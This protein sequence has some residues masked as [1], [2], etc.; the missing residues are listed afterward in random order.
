M[1]AGYLFKAR[2]FGPVF[3]PNGTSGPDLFNRWTRGACY[4]DIQALWG[5]R[6]LF[7]HRFPYL[8]GGMDS[9]GG[10]VGG[11]LEYPVLS[12]L[13]IW[14]AAVPSATD[15]DLL[16][17]SALMLGLCGLGIAFL[18]ARLTGWRSLWWSLAPALVLYTVLNWDMFAVVATVGAI[19]AVVA[20]TRSGTGRGDAGTGHRTGWL[21]LAAVLLAVGGLLKLYP[22]MFVLPIALWIALGDR[23]TGADPE[24]RRDRWL[25]AAGFGGMATAVFVLVNLPF[26][27]WNFDGW[28]AAYRFQW[29]RPIDQ[30]T[31]SIWYWGLRPYSESANL[32]LQQLMALGATAAT[33]LSLIAICLFGL[34]RR[35]RDG[36]YPWLQVSA[37]MLCA[38]LIFNKVHS[39]QYALWMIPFLV[40]IRIPA[41]W[42]LGYFVADVMTG[43]GFLKMI[44]SGTDSITASVWPQVLIL[45]VWGRVVLLALLIVVFLRAEPAFGVGGAVAALSGP[46]DPVDRHP[47]EIPVVPSR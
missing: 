42:I 8:N 17:W 26:V 43:V 14:L 16:R 20:G 31:N 28:W 22:L 45:G 21:M 34:W 38:Y 6:Q 18:L 13:L 29:K 19:A 27:L 4:T 2:C 36:V 44:G 5:G 40:L 24:P 39:P 15:L 3:D 33:G 47:V 41:P 1:V 32:D 25:R 46:V 23:S 12:G 9:G 35:H 30:S 11:A 10:L 37:A 7:E